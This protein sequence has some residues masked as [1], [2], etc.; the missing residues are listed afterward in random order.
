MNKVRT[1]GKRTL[2]VLSA[3]MIPLTGM[4][5]SAPVVNAA[6]NEVHF[7]TTKSSI[8][9]SNDKGSTTIEKRSI[10]KKDN[11]KLEY[12]YT[13][14]LFIAN[15]SMYDYHSD[16]EKDGGSITD[17]TAAGFTDAYTEFNK[18]ISNEKKPYGLISASSENVT[19]RYKSS[20]KGEVKAYLYKD[21]QF[22]NVWQGQVMSYDSQAGEYVLTFG[23]ESLGFI[24]KYVIFNWNGGE[25]G[26]KTADL[27]I[28]WQKGKS[29]VYSDGGNVTE[30]GT[31]KDIYGEACLYD[32]PLYFGCFYREYTQNVD[33]YT[34]FK[35]NNK[36]DGTLRG[37][38]GY[39]FYSN[40]Y[41]QSNISLRGNYAASVQGLVDDE[42]TNGTITQ[43]GVK[44][45][46]FNDDW[47]DNHSNLVKYWHD[48]AFPF[49][50]INVD[51]ADVHGD[52]AD[53]D[54]NKYVA[55]YYQFNSKERN[56]YLKTDD[57]NK[58]AV[59]EETNTVIKSQETVIRDSNGNITDNKKRTEC[60]L[61]FNSYDNAKLNNLGF[62]TTFEM[63]FKIRSDG[64]VDT[65]DKTTGKP[66][67][68][69]VNATFEFMGDDDVW[70]FI[71]DKLVLDLGGAHKDT[72][73]IIDFAEK[74]A[75][76]N[77]A[78]EFGY[79]GRDNLQKDLATQK[80]VNLQ[81][82]MAEGTFD[83]QGNYDETVTHHLKMFYM[84]RGMYES[85]LLVRFNFA[86]IPNNNTL[87][88]R[89]I[90]QF[91]NINP[92]LLD[93]TKKAADYDVFDYSISNSGTSTDDVSDSGIVSP[94]Y[95]YYQ[96]DNLGQKALLSGQK[97]VPYIYLDI[98]ETL[99]GKKWNADNA[100]MGAKLS[101][102]GLA[103]KIVV[104]EKIGDYLYR[105]DVSGGYTKVDFQ[106]LAT[107][108]DTAWNTAGIGTFEEGATYKITG[109][110]S[111]AF[112]HSGSSTEYNENNF[113]PTQGNVVKNVNYIWTDK[114]AD[115]IKGTDTNG[116]VGTTDGRG[117]FRLMYGTD[118]KESSAEF[119]KQFKKGSQMTVNQLDTMRTVERTDVE[120]TPETFG[121]TRSRSSREYYDTTVTVEDKNGNT[122]LSGAMTDTDYAYQNTG[123]VD[124]KEPVQITETFVNTPKV[125]AITVTKQLDP[126]DNVTDE[127][128]FT[129]RLYDVFGI[130]DMNVT[131]YSAITANKPITNITDNT[132]G[133]LGQFILKRDETLTIQGVP[134][135]T[136]YTITETP[137]EN[138]EQESNSAET[139]QTVY[140]GTFNTE[141]DV[142]NPDER[143]EET[144][145]NTRLTNSLTL[146]KI[147]EGEYTGTDIDN[148]T[149]FTF[150]VMLTAPT[151]V[152]LKDYTF[153]T[154]P[155]GIV[156]ADKNSFTVQVSVNQSVTISG[157]PYDTGYTVS[158][159]TSMANWSNDGDKTGTIGETAS[160]AVIT[161]T[162]T[163]PAVGNLEITKNVLTPTGS[164]DIEESDKALVFEFTVTLTDMSGSALT[165]DDTYDI[166]KSSVTG[167]TDD[168]LIFVK[169][170][171]TVTLSDDES[172][173]IK[174]IPAGYHYAV[175]ESYMAGF[176]PKSTNDTGVIA[177]AT[178]LTASFTN[179]KI[180]KPYVLP[181]AGFEDSRM[182]F[183]FILSGMFMF[184]I[185]YWYVNR[186]KAKR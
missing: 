43:S 21:S 83:A 50:E 103:D 52:V 99:N 158:E 74:K 30:D 49:Y 33:T 121:T 144:V 11:T 186:S 102:D 73:G 12:D 101:G 128:V 127:F 14:N 28:D 45:P 125:G 134:Y 19:V 114:F 17:S 177:D 164:E 149:L 48:I 87:K 143:N 156:I 34:S 146:S 112:D 67:G 58:T 64:K 55:K 183:V 160:T 8:V 5:S 180:F 68:K 80:T 166:T 44:L 181:D 95:N 96:R 147:L 167:K 182:Y 130:K 15:S 98:S 157:I 93:L 20:N 169:G 139:E 120:N 175:T 70:V 126:N 53:G 185:A 13:G 111:A 110:T 78:L 75:I 154:D 117:T 42:L 140:E 162:Y 36:G 123:S 86:T 137:A 178:T 31:A 133:T 7:D 41:W 168:T 179:T 118:D 62:G 25:G 135:G 63:S 172:I 76:A 100:R 107:S 115:V 89:E 6:S 161:N 57:A 152:D 105:F 151:G 116:L 37:T 119:Q 109:W 18:T 79:G 54:N 94:T 136:K 56:L 155:D 104:G 4:F 165:T 113:D 176:T 145:V 16:Q 39:N 163:P 81:D 173:V 26:N 150:N 40:F 159:V 35:Y 92:G 82:V 106:R 32:I 108:S 69:S 90:T 184:G 47:A 24:P 132:F 9:T 97:I 22:N 3:C 29:Y 2:A 46:Y 124:A 91:K 131:D 170:V 77:D 10:A 85:D 122:I 71:D 153:T 141:K 174:G 88:V 61:P 60:Y 38:N 23:Y 27:A 171:A 59:Y 138:Y 66:T 65:F 142:I 72:T 129:L 148:D 51:A 1:F 84:E